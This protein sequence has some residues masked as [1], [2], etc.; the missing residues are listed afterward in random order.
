MVITTSIIG[1][2]VTGI[3]NTLKLRLAD[4][5]AKRRL[6]DELASQSPRER[7]DLDVMRGNLGVSGGFGR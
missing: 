4:W 6:A 2:V 7:L 5:Q 3:A 1:P